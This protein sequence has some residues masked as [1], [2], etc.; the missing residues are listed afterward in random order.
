MNDTNII[1]ND[2]IWTNH[3]E[4]KYETDI[5][6][7]FTEILLDIYT[8]FNQKYLSRIL[9]AT[10]PLFY[11]SDYGNTNEDIYLQNQPQ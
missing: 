1:I 8:A 7:I 10:G 3:Q 9:T 6:D 5:I 2:I 11:F 4:K